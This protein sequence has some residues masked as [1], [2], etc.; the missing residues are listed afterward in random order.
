MVSRPQITGSGFLIPVSE[1]R[2][3]EGC[4]MAAAVRG[5]TRAHSAAR[6]R[7]MREG[8]QGASREALSAFGSSAL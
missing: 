4:T 3:R 7:E 2:Q 1:A 8:T 5:A 6:S